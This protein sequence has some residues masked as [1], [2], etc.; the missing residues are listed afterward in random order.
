MRGDD[1]ARRKGF[2]LPSRTVRTL[3]GTELVEEKH[4]A[5]LVGNVLPASKV[6]V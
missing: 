2:P 5:A 3:W 6:T 1:L 4:T